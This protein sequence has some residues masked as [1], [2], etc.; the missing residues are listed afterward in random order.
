MHNFVKSQKLCQSLCKGTAVIG[1]A[2]VV[3]QP[4]GEA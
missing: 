4:V 1:Y 2:V 3:P